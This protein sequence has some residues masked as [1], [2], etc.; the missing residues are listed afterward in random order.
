MK[1]QVSSSRF[2][3]IPLLA[4][5]SSLAVVACDN[6]PVGEASQA[7]TAAPGA[8]AAA[9]SEG[10]LKLSFSE[11][12]STL[13][14]VG[15]KITAKHDGAFKKFS[16]E[17]HLDEKNLEAS[18]VSV[19]I[20]MSEF[21]ITPDKLASHLKSPDF[22]DVEKFPEAKFVST[23][24]EKTDAGHTV[25]GNLTLHGVTKAI[26]FPATIKAHDKK[27]KVNA[28]FGINRKDFGIVYPGM[29]DDLINDEVLIKIQLN[30]G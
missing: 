10:A 14:F 12:G 17:V 9:P 8:P 22:F 29:P 1:I 11:Q 2:P 25:T 5:V 16:G 27:V 20:A 7:Q 15:A 19:T 24:L 26:S 28:E 18:T 13:D 23:K 3:L 21:A 6:D 4:L 30:A